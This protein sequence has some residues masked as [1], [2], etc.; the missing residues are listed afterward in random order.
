M[1]ISRKKRKEDP[2]KLYFHNEGIVVPQV[3][4]LDNSGANLGTMNTGEA[5]RSAREQEMDLV[6]INPKVDP[7]VAKIMDFG[8]FQYQQ[9]KEARIKK[10]HQ[11]VTK[12]KC[13]RLSLRIGAHD[14]EI[15][16]K[17]AMDFLNEGDKAKVELI[18][19]GRENQQAVLGFETMR[20]FV[21][22]INAEVPT[23]FDQNVEKQGS[24]ISVILT[25]T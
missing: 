11:H 15:R 17:Q 1:R 23:K 2:K 6:L 21:A 9:E 25:K 8:H 24:V 3:M 10:A 16:R 19:R 7:P 22:S 13:V 20:K 5:I 14:M 18:L 12:V 4:V